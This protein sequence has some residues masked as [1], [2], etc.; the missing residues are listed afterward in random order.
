MDR[1]GKMQ[2]FKGSRKFENLTQIQCLRIIHDI[3]LRKLRNIGS[4]TQL[5][6]EKNKRKLEIVKNINKIRSQAKWIELEAEL[7]TKSKFLH[8]KVEQIQNEISN[9]IEKMIHKEQNSESD[10]D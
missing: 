2:A 3:N 5:R 1:L 4:E 6:L 8:Q 7:S 9:I 10:S